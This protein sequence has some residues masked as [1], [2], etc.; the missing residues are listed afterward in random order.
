M[1]L[2]FLHLPKTGGTSLHKLLQA[3]FE[4]DEICPERFNG[5]GR[6]SNKELQ[7]YNFF[8]AHMDFHSLER[9]ANPAYTVT[10]L[11][12]PK[13]RIVS[14]FHYWK[15]QKREHIERHNLVG[16]RF[17]KDTCLAEFL[18]TLPKE[19]MKDVD[20]AYVRNFLGRL[21]TGPTGEFLIDEDE[22]L[23]V[24]MRNLL[25]IDEVGFTDDLRNFVDRVFLKLSIPSPEEL[26]KAR[27]RVGFGKDDP[28]TEEIKFEEVTPE[29]DHLLEHF[30]RLDSKF[31][32][33]ARAIFK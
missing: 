33:S 30:T 25:K 12:E 29:I 26:P 4:T 15:A 7:E 18:S 16:P 31:Y 23:R 22:A 3:A 13:Q 20:N 17:A 27:S 10:L 32:H 8:S 5:F 28:N 1:R 21:W 11:R 14:L 9:V 19:L 24:A 6:F 2:A